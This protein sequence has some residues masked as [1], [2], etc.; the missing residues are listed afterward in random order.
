[1]MSLLYRQDDVWVKVVLR[2]RLTVQSKIKGG[3]Q[4]DSCTDVEFGGRV[5]LGWR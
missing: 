4:S 5:T 3:V 2:S 1:M